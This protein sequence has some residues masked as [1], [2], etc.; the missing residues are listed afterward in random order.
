MHMQKAF[1]QAL[2]PSSFWGKL[3]QLQSAAEEYYT[4]GSEGYYGPTET[5]GSFTGIQK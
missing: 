1:P 4:T 5:A 2:K 3:Q